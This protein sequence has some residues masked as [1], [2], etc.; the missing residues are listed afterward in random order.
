[1]R[2]RLRIVLAI[3]S[4]AVALGCK[5]GGNLANDTVSSPAVTMIRNMH[6]TIT[7]ASTGSC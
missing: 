2:R 7:A 6:G 5:P 3:P 1:M 4:P